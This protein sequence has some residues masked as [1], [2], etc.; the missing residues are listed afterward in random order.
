VG[1]GFTYAAKEHARLPVLCSIFHDDFALAA[2]IIDGSKQDKQH[3]ETTQSWKSSNLVLCVSL[4]LLEC[5][6]FNIRSYNV[7]LCHGF[8]EAR[9]RECVIALVQVGGFYL[10]DVSPVCASQCPCH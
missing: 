1:G 9:I 7:D 2:N 10:A 5:S 4:R 3:H 8:S 6:L